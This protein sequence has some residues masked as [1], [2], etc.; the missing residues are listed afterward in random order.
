[1]L[2][3]SFPCHSCTTLLIHIAYDHTT[4][5]PRVIIPYT[6]LCYSCTTPHSLSNLCTI[7]QF[8]HMSITHNYTLDIDS[9][10]FIDH[11]CITVPPLLIHAA[12]SSSRKYQ[13]QSL[14]GITSK[15]FYC[16][17]QQQV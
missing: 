6:Q 4:L 8:F 7:Q 9:S 15:I 14:G 13:Y 5:L 17:K 10:S 11:S 12:H 1:M 2:R 16:R 3:L